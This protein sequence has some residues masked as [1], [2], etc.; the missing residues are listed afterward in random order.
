MSSGG[1]SERQRWM[2]VGLAALFAG[3]AIGGAWGVQRV[4]A[5]RYATAAMT[6]FLRNDDQGAIMASS[7]ALAIVP[8]LERA[9]IPRIQAQFEI[10][11]CDEL[12]TT[13]LKTLAANPKNVRAY[14]YRAICETYKG[15]RELAVQ[16]A[17]R[18]VGLSP[19]RA[20]AHVAKAYAFMGTRDFEEAITSARRAVAFD[21]ELALSHAALGV[22]LAL[23]GRPDRLALAASECEKAVS[24]RPR[25]AE[26]WRCR[27]LVANAAGDYAGALAATDKAIKLAPT[28]SPAYGV[29]VAAHVGLGRHDAAIRVFKVAAA[30]WPNDAKYRLQLC[31]TLLLRGRA[32][33]TLA[34]L[35]E[36]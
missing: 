13:A 7:K 24:I 27:G 9:L 31:D 3:A 15:H 17:A 10:A 26:A 33:D 4:R 36:Q 12:E 25:L 21:D 19:Q 32:S 8:T 6:S 35:C 11:A 29:R 22:S 34:E 1:K 20:L 14:A 28:L 30:L 2:Y 23:A 18:A 5:H 16:Y